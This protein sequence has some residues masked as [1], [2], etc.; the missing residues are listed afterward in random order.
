MPAG[1]LLCRK[2]T[3]KLRKYLFD[4]NTWC[5]ISKNELY[6]NKSGK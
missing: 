6:E 4:K 1:F 5:L 3:V 2:A